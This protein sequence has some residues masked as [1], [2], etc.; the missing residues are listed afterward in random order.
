MLLVKPLPVVELFWRRMA[1]I[2]R[3]DP[4]A[5]WLWPATF[6]RQG[7]GVLFYGGKPQ[8]VLKAHRLSYELFVGP[9]PPGMDVCHRC[10]VPAC[11]NPMH[12]WIGTRGENIRDAVRKGRH[13]S[14][15]RK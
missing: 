5:C 11:I 9:I 15:F 3:S 12:L 2:D 14:P 7:Y 1:R 8:R 10:D 4:N 6:N 13:F